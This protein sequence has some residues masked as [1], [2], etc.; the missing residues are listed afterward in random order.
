MNRLRTILPALLVLLCLS[1]S[2]EQECTVIPRPLSVQSEGGFFRAGVPFAVAVEAPETVANALTDYLSSSSLPCHRCDTAATLRLELSDDASLP[3]SDEGYTLEVRPDRIVVRSRGEA[4]LFY[5]IQSLLQLYD[6]HGAR[7][8]ALQIADSPRFAYRGMHLDVSRHFFGKEFVKKQLRMMAS[9]KLN[10]LHWHLTDG[11]GWRIAIDRYPLLTEVAAWRREPTWQ[12]WQAGNRHYSTASA[13]GAYGGYY[14]KDDIREVLACA[15]S[16]HITV[17]PEIEMPGH[18]EE[19]LAVCP[20]LSCAGKPYVS[21]EFCLGSEATFVFLENVLSEVTELFP[22]EYIHIGGDEVS[23]QAWASCPKCRAR[24]EREGLGSAQELQA[25]AIRRIGRFLEAR[26]R[27]LVGWDEILDSGPM[28]DAAVMSWR[29]EEGGRRAAA[30]GH[31]VVMCPG[32]HCYFDGFQDN[33][34]REPQ[35]FT[36]YLPLSKVYS[37]DPAPAA[38]S[39]REHIIGVQANLWTEYIPTPS[40]AEYM[41]Y[42]RMFALAEVAWSAPETKDYA[43]FRRRALRFCDRARRQ[44]YHTFDLRA[45]FGERTESLAPVRHLAVGCPVHYT[46]PWHPDY[47]ADGTAALTDGLRGPWSYGTRWQGFRDTDMEVTVDLGRVRPLRSI[48]ADFIQWHSAWI[49]LP[50]QVEFSVSDDNSGFR[51]LAA[52]PNGLPS[53]CH[54][55]AYR[56]FAWHGETTGR[57][58]RCRARSQGFPGGWLFTDEIIVN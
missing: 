51:T 43:D 20:E 37:Y 45:E 17:I 28:P 35:A 50:A 3:L 24:M 13:P 21:G 11:A 47:P 57:Y 16:L 39:G 7:I 31:D 19:V 40:Q 46:Y 14:T 48:A 4:G 42:P 8:P 10:R 53:D 12:A 1:C 58:V 36:G 32:S 38:L 52:L 29:G 6:R 15:D 54:R 25:Y 30:L 22:S 23:G 26:G 27:K 18:S 44:G 34:E 2:G 9:L 5:G 33:P 55:P 56:T 41:L 49:W